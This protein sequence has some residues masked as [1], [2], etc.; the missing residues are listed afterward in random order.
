MTYEPHKQLELLLRVAI[1][2][3]DIDIIQSTLGALKKY[4]C[5]T[6]RDEKRD[7]RKAA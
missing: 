5:E 1:A 3:G 6:A 7:G 2:Q 4:D